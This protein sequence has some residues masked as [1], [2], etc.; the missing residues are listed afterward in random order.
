VTARLE[1]ILDIKRNYPSPALHLS[2]H[3]IA[4]F[5]SPSVRGGG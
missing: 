1:R 2:R 5:C 4:H 3:S